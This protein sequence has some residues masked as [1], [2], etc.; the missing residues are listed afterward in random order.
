MLVA[1]A[2]PIAVIVPVGPRDYHREYLPEFVRSVEQQTMT[3][4]E[5]VFID[6]GGGLLEGTS[7]LEAPT[8]GTCKTHIIRN[9]WN[10]GVAASM[11]VG[12]GS[13]SYD[14]A[15]MACA[16]D[17]L[18]PRCVELCWKAWEREKN[19]LGYY[20][21]GLRYSGTGEEQNTP[22]GAA[23]VTR[24]L[25]RRSGGFPP[26]CAVG[27]AD[28]IFLHGMLLASRN[29]RLDVKFLRVSDEIVYWYRRHTTANS[30]TS[31]NCWPAIE[32]VKD[33]YGS[34]WQ[35]IVGNEVASNTI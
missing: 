35:P 20:F 8:V 31:R 30:E 10:L 21:F 23:M 24:E 7:R 28:H 27:A 25:W 32:A 5:V 33:W 12:I 9:R 18:L 4:A 14:L 11:N 1:N 13:T 6:D 29:D 3:P 26:Q 19:P 16:D 22:C 34:K 2:A 15:I 17:M